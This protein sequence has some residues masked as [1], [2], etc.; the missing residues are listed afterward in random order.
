MVI[1]LVVEADESQ[2]GNNVYVRMRQA[3]T[4]NNLQLIKGYKFTNS[5]IKY[6][7]SMYTIVTYNLT[8]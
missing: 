6:E 2:L 7:C 1:T 8:D 3:R 5:I 4:A